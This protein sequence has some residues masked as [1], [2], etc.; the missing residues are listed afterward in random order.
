MIIL[1]IIFLPLIVSVFLVALKPSGARWIAF[2][3]GLAELVLTLIPICR[4]AGESLK[5]TALWSDGLGMSFSLNADGISMILIL[6]T[7]IL[8]PLIILTVRETHKSSLYY[9]LILFSQMAFNGVF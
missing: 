5:Y 7:N 9:G 6:L 3:A 1:T 2:S 8:I 4:P